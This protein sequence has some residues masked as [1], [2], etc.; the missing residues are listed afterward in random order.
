MIIFWDIMPSSPLKVNPM[1]WS[2]TSI[3]W[4]KNKPE[5]NQHEAGHKQSLFSDP[6][7]G[8]DMFL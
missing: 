8:G 3:F 6:E 5:R 2:V 4:S 1:F 7:D